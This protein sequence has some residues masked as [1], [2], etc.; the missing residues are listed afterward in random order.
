MLLNT[1]EKEKRQLR[2]KENGK[3]N[4]RE[5]T[6]PTLGLVTAYLTQGRS[7]MRRDITDH[8]L[9]LDTPIPGI[10][11]LDTLI[12]VIQTLAIQTLDTL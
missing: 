11:T 3:E 5:N 10:L 12:L 6:D 2:G 1:D 4:E 9:T 8:L 7:I